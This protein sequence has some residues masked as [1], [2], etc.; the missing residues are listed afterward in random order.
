MAWFRRSMSQD[1]LDRLKSE[2]EDLRAAIA[3]HDAQRAQAEAAVAANGNGNGNGDGNSDHADPTER[4]D[5]LA[6]KLDELATRPFV[7]PERLDE[8]ALRLSELDQRVTSVSTELA[9]QVTEL[10]N[11]IDALA[12]RPEGPGAAAVDELRDGQVRLANEQAR[13]QIAFREDLARLAEQLRRAP[14]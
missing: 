1:E 13:Y 8:F 5:A 9:N 10:G 4:L 11:D 12:R 3:A 2:I 14:A 6:G 7:P